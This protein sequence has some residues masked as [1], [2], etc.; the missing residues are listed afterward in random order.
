MPIPTWI[1]LLTSRTGRFNPFPS[2]LEQQAHRHAGMMGKG[3][4]KRGAPFAE[5]T[6]YR[7]PC[8]GPLRVGL[9]GFQ[10]RHRC[11]AA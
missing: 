9:H 1:T 8:H 6:G 3:E 11:P 2:R 4:N 10:N 7:R 5:M